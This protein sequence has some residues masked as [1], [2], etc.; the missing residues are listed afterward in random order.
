M[1]QLNLPKRGKWRKTVQQSMQLFC[2][3]KLSTDLGEDVFCV[4]NSTVMFAGAPSVRTP[5]TA[6]CWKLHGSETLQ[7]WDRNTCSS[8]PL[9]FTSY[10]I[11]WR[12]SVLLLLI[13][14]PLCANWTWL[15]Y[16][17]TGLKLIPAAKGGYWSSCSKGVSQLHPAGS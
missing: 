8:W 6:L 12:S 15:M 17:I 4:G 7:V 2:R 3:M 14:T 9:L 5:S 10:C 1:I 11:S 16:L 13:T